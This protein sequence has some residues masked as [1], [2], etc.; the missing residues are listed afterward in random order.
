[1]KRTALFFLIV[2]FVLSAFADTSIQNTFFNCTLGKSTSAEVKSALQSKG[3]QLTSEETKEN[4]VD[5]HFNGDY[6]LNGVPFNAIHATF[7]KDTLLIFCTIDSCAEKVQEHE[8][9]LK[10]YLETRYA[11]LELADSSFLYSLVK[12][13]ADIYGVQTW[14]RKDE[15]TM[16]I[17]THS[18]VNVSCM[19][20]SQDL[21][22]SLMFNVFHQMQ[23]VLQSLPDYSEENKFY[24]V[25]GVKFGDSKNTVRGIISA[26]SSRLVDED[27]YTLT[28]INTK[29]GGTTYDFTIFYFSPGKGLISVCLQNAFYSWKKEEAIMAYKSTVNQYGRKYTNFKSLQ[30]DYEEKLSTCGAFI[31]GY[32]FPPITI[33]FK[34]GLSSG[35]DTMYYV[36]VNYY[37]MRRQSLYDDEI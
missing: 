6:E 25:A 30:D 19:Y 16:I 31:D 8:K 35:G 5:Y 12:D 27:A 3:L 15:H 4:S 2:L 22:L 37:E 36:I 11:N 13:S 7:Y 33:Q 14:A 28:Y 23:E 10:N 26:K 24:G 21:Y 1:M 18:D 20:I 34:Q 32:D 9:H 29:I 17:A